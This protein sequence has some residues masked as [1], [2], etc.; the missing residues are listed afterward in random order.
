MSMITLTFESFKCKDCGFIS[1]GAELH[2]F[3]SVA[4]PPEEFSYNGECAEC[5]SANTEKTN[6]PTKPASGQ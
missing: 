4:P 5:G 6:F 3:N 2:S 1:P